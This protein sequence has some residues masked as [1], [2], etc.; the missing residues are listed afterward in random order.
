VISTR[1]WKNA[2][3]YLLGLLAA[4][5]PMLLV[6]PFPVL[7]QHLVVFPFLQYAEPNFVSPNLLFA[8]FALLFAVAVLAWRTRLSASGFWPLWLVAALQLFTIWSRA[9]I[10]YLALV[11]WPLP[12]LFVAITAHR[13]E[14]P[15]VPP[16]PRIAKVFFYYASFLLVAQLIGWSAIPVS[17]AF[18]IT[19]HGNVRDR[20]LL[21]DPFWSAVADEVVRR[22]GPGEPIFATPYIPATYFFTQRPNATR[23]N[24]LLSRLHPQDFFAE[25]VASL[26]R[27]KPK[28]VVRVLGSF[29]VGRGFHRDGTVV[30]H[31][32]D[33]HYHVVMP[34][35]NGYTIQILERNS[36]IP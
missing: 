28:I 8:T 16:W 13:W 36:E 4:L 32:L 17:A 22:T 6:A 10:R 18:V 23:Y 3:G 11:L 27:V 34:T 9:D 31:Y 14:W 30:D 26:E 12:I 19:P 7:W 20:F 21:R 25:T 15:T 33:T 5:A 29:A 1:R 2:A 24:V 35:V